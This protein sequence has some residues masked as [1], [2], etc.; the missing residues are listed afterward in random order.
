LAGRFHGVQDFI[1]LAT[2]ADDL[3]ELAEYLSGGRAGREF[4]VG[5]QP[6][7]KLVARIGDGTENGRANPRVCGIAPGDGG[8][9]INGAL[10]DW[11]GSAGAPPAVRRALASNTRG[12]GGGGTASCARCGGAPHLKWKEFGEGKGQVESDA[13]VGFGSG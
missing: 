3:G 10:A 2:D 7:E 13:R 6:S 11:L 12:A 5:E 8:E 4:R 1:V 9:G